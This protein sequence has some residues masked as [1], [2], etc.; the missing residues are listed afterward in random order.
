MTLK[1]CLAADNA[2]VSFRKSFVF[3]PSTFLPS[4]HHLFQGASAV[5]VQSSSI[6]IK[7][8]CDQTIR[9]QLKIM[10]GTRD[11]SRAGPSPSW[12][13]FAA[14]PIPSSTRGH[15]YLTRCAASIRWKKPAMSEMA[16]EKRQVAALWM[17]VRRDPQHPCYILLL[18]RCLD[19]EPQVWEWDV[20][21]RSTIRS[22]TQRTRLVFRLIDSAFIIFL[23]S[24]IKPLSPDL[25]LHLWCYLLTSFTTFLRKILTKW[26]TSQG[27]N[28]LRNESCEAT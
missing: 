12:Q 18:S 13:P 23:L 5:R 2:N 6:Q 11:K 8:G 3:L 27:E 28:I 22:A 26:T 1:P 16:R 15:K 4:T 9:R 21:C 10:G 14:P 19:S 17:R 25:M 7:P 24:Q 20:R